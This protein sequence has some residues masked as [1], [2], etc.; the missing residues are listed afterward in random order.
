MGHPRRARRV[1]RRSGGPRDHRPDREQLGRLRRSRRRSRDHPDRRHRRARRLRR[2]DHRPGRPRRGPR[3][4]RAPHLRQL[5]A[6]RGAPR[7]RPGL[8]AGAGH[9]QDELVRGAMAGRHRR[10]P[11]AL[12]PPWRRPGD[13]RPRVAQLSHAPPG[14][15]RPTRLVDH[16]L[17]APRARRHRL[18]SRPLYQQL[19]RPHRRRHMAALFDGGPHGRRPG[20][21]LPSPG[22]RQRPRR[23]RDV[24][25]R[26]RR[27]GRR[28]ADPG[29]L[30]AHGER[31]DGLHGARRR[32]RDR[33]ARRRRRPRRLRRR[34]HPSR[35]AGR[36]PGRA[37]A[38]P[39]LHRRALRLRPELLGRARGRQDELVPVLPARR[40]GHA[41]RAL[42]RAGAHVDARRPRLRALRHSAPRGRRAAPRLV[43]HDLH[44][45]ARG[46]R[47]GLV[48]P[49]RASSTT[50]TTTPLSTSG[51]AT[52][53]STP[54]APSGR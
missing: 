2:R 33:A 50:T 22:R 34:H 20:D 11:A 39:P 54:P 31:L 1:G 26:P 37:A 30:P 4:A 40:V 47:R 6:P 46:G 23:R 41:L 53:P 44:P 17:H 35:P 21:E 32:P 10:P 13:R 48:V 15:R 51:R 27:R 25:G 16:H 12:P 43:D 36:G 3:R 29:H 14:G 19:R 45:Q 38:P 42:P 7:L 8:L 28:G 52:R 24:A 5:C 49:P 9:R 18:V